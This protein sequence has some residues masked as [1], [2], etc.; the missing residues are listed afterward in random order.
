MTGWLL[1]A[2]AA[3][4]PLWSG[5]EAMTVPDEPPRY[6][7]PAPAAEPVAEFV[8]WLDHMNPPV[9]EPGTGSPE[10]AMQLRVKP[11]PDH[12]IK[13]LDAEGL[14]RKFDGIGYRLTAVRRGAVHVPRLFVDEMPRDMR[15]IE[16]PDLR[17]RLFIRAMLPLI[18]RANEEVR[19]ERQALQKIALRLRR[20]QP[21]SNSDLAFL[22]QMRAV[23]A[24]AR[25]T[26][27]ELLR[28]VDVVPPSLA[29]AQAA[30]E[31][32]WGTSRFVREGN[33]VFGQRTFKGDGLV[34]LRRERD[35]THRVRNFSHVQ[36]SVAAY[37]FNLNTHPAYKGFRTL[38]AQMRE[39]GEPLDSDALVD[40]LDRY[41]E[42]GRAY[43]KTIRTILRVNELA[44]FDAVKLSPHNR[45]APNRTPDIQPVRWSF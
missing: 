42:R 1:P 35:K 8:A 12:V 18:L 11:A 23:Y 37:V 27:D 4:V 31:S 34:P 39:K 9:V 33:A 14:A 3:A 25:C 30:E 17:K 19:R 38:R 26:V 24:D 10:P 44:Q 43:T 7:A 2:V 5:E 13:P 41:S 15:A 29:L 20:G 6:A 40:A 22:D 36:A 45:E 21:L 32:G 16:S 28:R